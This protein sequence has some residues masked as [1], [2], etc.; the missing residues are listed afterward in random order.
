MLSAVSKAARRRKASPS[1]ALA[2]VE[3]VER[4]AGRHAITVPAEGMTAA[5]F[6]KQSTSGEAVAFLATVM[7]R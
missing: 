7:V 4:F 1:K 5:R 6:E 3:A 2:H